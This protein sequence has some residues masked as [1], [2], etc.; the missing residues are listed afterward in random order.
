MFV[1]L[2]ASRI[3]SLVFL[4]VPSLSPPPALLF[5][6][7][8]YLFIYFLSTELSGSSV[9]GAWGV[10]GTGGSWLGCGLGRP[11]GCSSALG[12]WLRL[13]PPGFL[14]TYP[15][16]ATWALT[17]QYLKIDSIVDGIMRYCRALLRANFKW[18]VH[19]GTWLFIQR[20][21]FFLVY[22][23]RVSIAL[24]C[25]YPSTMC[26][27]QFIF[28]SGSVAQWLGRLPWD[29][30]FRVQDPLWPLAEFVPGS[31]WFN[32]PAALVNS[33]PVCLRPVG[34]LNSC[35][36]CVLLFRWLFHWPWKAPMGSGQLSMYCIVLYCN[37]WFLGV[38]VEEQLQHTFPG[39][40]FGWRYHI[41]PSQFSS[42]STWVSLFK[43]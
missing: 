1:A 11:V 38:D 2:L 39:T 3:S 28:T 21:D 34:I 4:G 6:F 27:A 33:Q 25:P 36:C 8:F 31:P 5:F 26:S 10:P 17:V 32:F 40:L 14:G 42:V 18:K 12:M 20:S 41:G 13:Q 19:I 24:T 37:C 35:C 29:L 43:D 9:T 23:G 7:I 30:E 22:T 16:L 15:P